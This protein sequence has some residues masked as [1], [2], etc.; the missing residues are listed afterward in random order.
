MSITILLYHQIIVRLLIYNPFLLYGLIIF[1]LSPS[2][3][4]LSCV[5][6]FAFG[7]HIICN[8]PVMAGSIR[9]LSEVAAYLQKFSVVKF[10]RISNS[11]VLRYFSIDDFIPPGPR[12]EWA[13]RPIR[14]KI[15]ERVC[16]YDVLK[17][18][19]AVVPASPSA[20]VSPAAL[21][22]YIFLRGN[23]LDPDNAKQHFM[24]L[25]EFAHC[26]AISATAHTF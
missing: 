26:A 14:K 7:A 21:G 1:V 17:A 9:Q 12:P 15:L 19:G 16:V 2:F 13:M 4:G 3:P 6:I 11:I 18:L 8:Q 24:M 5:L 22:F 20:F 10:E 23:H 25:H